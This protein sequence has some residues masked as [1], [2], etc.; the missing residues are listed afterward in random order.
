MAINDKTRKNLWAKSGNRCSICKVELFS[1]LKDKNNL[2]IGE[3]CHIISSKENGPRFK[4]G[5]ID[6]DT[7]E[8][9][10]LLCGNHHKEID[11]LT[12]TFTE[13]II[14]YIKTNH[15]NWVGNTLNNAI[16]S[17]QNKAPK[18]L[19]RITS[20]KELFNIISECLAS[21][22]D[23]DEAES[24]EEANYIASVFQQFSDFCDLSDTVDPYDKVKMGFELNELL[25]ELDIKGYFL[26]GERTLEK[27][28]FSN[29]ETDKWSIATL[30]LRKKENKDVIKIDLT[31]LP[32]EKSEQ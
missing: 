16:N 20:G 23:Y 17:V 14:R 24:E 30:I 27:V 19:A 32:V 10:I 13:E 15:E 5:I 28:K 3:E 8:N 11:S 29:G 22:I 26:F 6:Y 25:K 4:I 2:N 7:Y 21:N 1:T 9:L 18:F 31:K 12:E